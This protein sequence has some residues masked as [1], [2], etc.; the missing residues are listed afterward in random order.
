MMLMTLI[1]AM[2]L[3]RITSSRWMGWD[4]SLGRVP[5]ALSPLTESKPNMMPSRG[6]RKLTKMISGNGTGSAVTVKSLRNSAVMPSA[7]GATSLIPPEA[8][9]TAAAVA[10]PS[11]ASRTTKRPE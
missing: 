4:S 11:T 7:F 2:N 1:P 9:K 3:P 8:A 10:I 5:W 6:A